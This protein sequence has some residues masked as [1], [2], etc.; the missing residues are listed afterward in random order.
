MSEQHDADDILVEAM[1]PNGNIMAIVQATPA[2]VHLYL[3]AR[4]ETNF[5]MRA[6]WV[7]NLAPAP[8]AIRA[9]VVQ[10]GEPPMMPAATCAHPQGAPLPDSD[11]LRVIWF[12]EGDSA[13]LFE[14]DEMLAA[15]PPWSGVEGFHGYA[16]DCTGESPLAWPLKEATVIPQRAA[17]AAE[18][19]RSWEPGRAHWPAVQ[20]AFLGAYE[21]VFG[22]HKQYW[23]IDGGKWPPRAVASFETDAA[24]VLLTLGVSIR[25]MP[26]VELA[27]EDP[28][29]HRRIELGFAFDRAIANDEMIHD[30]VSYMSGQSS[31]P[32]QFYTWLGVGHTVQCEPCPAGSE[33][34][35][36][37][38]VTD[39]PGAPA[40]A[41]PTYR[42]D[43]V[44]LLWVV[45][46]TAAEWK[47]AQEQSSS[48]VLKRLQA[49]GPIWPHR[50]RAS[51]V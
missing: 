2:S 13:A 14:G 45:P 22:K 9:E 3:T 12:E 40:I 28:Q 20:D 10:R 8:A 1:S 26:K 38:L 33:F 31:L 27:F 25:P 34:A 46:I 17:R 21:R 42:D 37:M 5:G 11:A 23:G 36:V 39:P 7:R 16:R 32:W 41:M 44:N 15:I 18:F 48:E 51:V 30:A 24:L 29:P 49:Q 47:A 50:P 35:A 4:P 19:W 6:V 43:P